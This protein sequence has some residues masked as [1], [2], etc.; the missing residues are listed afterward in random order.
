MEMSFVSREEVMG[1]VETMVKH[2]FHHA[3]GIEL[4]DVFERLTYREAID[5]YG[6]D[7]PDL[8]FGLKLKDVGDIVKDTSFK[9]FLDTLSKGGMIKG[10]NAK[11][12][13][14]YSR[15]DLDDL[16]KEVQG[17]GAKGMAWMKVKGGIE[18]PIA[19]FFSEDVLAALIK[20]FEAGDGDLLL[21]VADRADVANDCLARLRNEI[22]R[23]LDLL[24]EGDFKFAWVTDFPLFEWN[25]EEK[26]YEA[27]HHPFTSPME[28]D[29]E[30]FMTTDARGV[31]GL[32][33]QAYDLVLNGYEIGGG[34][35]RIHRKELQD[36]MFQFLNISEDEASEKFGFLLEALQ[37]GAPPHGGIALGLDRLVM[38][39]AGAHSIR[40]VI[41]FPKTQKAVCPLS[42]A[43]S[44]V[45]ARQLQELSIKLDIIE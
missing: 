15:K 24:N 16:T 44:A 42:N 20:T 14:G 37:Y 30:K 35:I 7:K 45:D 25:E 33:A 13:A 34:S 40:D 23:R 2:V 4:P 10:L 39:M 32:R 3:A 17:Y 36:R 18:S 1:L 31:A 21:F 43:P 9:V 11:G 5:S 27:M 22:A 26:R 12:L 8:R 29:V 6:T 28:E 41:A 19:K 38:V